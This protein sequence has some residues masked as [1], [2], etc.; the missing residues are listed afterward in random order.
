M[1]WQ[2]TYAHK[3]PKLCSATLTKKLFIDSISIKTKMTKKLQKIVY[4]KIRQLSLLLYFALKQK[5]EKV[6]IFL[7]KL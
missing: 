4:K 6:S 3:L 5:M 1:I 2:M 7:Q